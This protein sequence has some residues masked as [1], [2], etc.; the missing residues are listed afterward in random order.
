MGEYDEDPTQEQDDLLDGHGAMGGGA[1]PGD[2]F[3]KTATGIKSVLPSIF[4]LK[5]VS[6]AGRLH[7]TIITN[8]TAKYVTVFSV[9]ES[10][11]RCEYVYGS[12]VYQ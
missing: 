11:H 7:F 6:E 5:V 9:L 1:T 2:L 4:N 10:R 3:I 8:I 12:P